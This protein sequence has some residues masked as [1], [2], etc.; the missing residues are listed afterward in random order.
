MARPVISGIFGGDKHITGR[1]QCLQF[2]MPMPKELVAYFYVYYFY[3]SCYG[4]H[5]YF[6]FY[7]HLCA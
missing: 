6:K 4:F 1:V 2:S 3:F 7:F 5:N